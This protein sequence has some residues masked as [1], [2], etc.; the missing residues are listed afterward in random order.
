MM[1]ESFRI[2]EATPDDLPAV[3][4][5]CRQ[6]ETED[7]TR[8]YR[9]DSVEKLSHRLGK[10]FLLAVRGGRIH[11][12]VIGEVKTTKDNEFVE[13]VL[14]DK[15]SYLE[16]QDLYVASNHRCH[17]I[18]TGLMK[19]L[20]DRVAHDNAGGSLVYSANRDYVRMANFYERL[21]YEM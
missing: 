14:D 19:E 7:I 9:A 17:G 15:P 5:L 1:T 8:N 6:W 2:R 16:V 12:F 13:G 20:L 21:G 3:A 10:C 11:G 18:G 4:E